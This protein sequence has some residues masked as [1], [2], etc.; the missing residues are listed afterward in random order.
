MRSRPIFLP[1]S[2]SLAFRCRAVVI[3][4]AC[5]LAAGCVIGDRIYTSNIDLLFPG[6]TKEQVRPLI[7]DAGSACGYMKG[8]QWKS[9]GR[10]FYDVCRRE[11]G[12]GCHTKFMKSALWVEAKEQTTAEA[13]SFWFDFVD[14]EGWIILEPRVKI[15]D[16]VGGTK[17][18]FGFSSLGT[19]LNPR[20]KTEYYALKRCLTER[21]G[22]A[23]TTKNEP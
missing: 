7:L 14:S 11:N 1:M 4:I 12:S 23:V 19:P 2:V 21:Y 13:I 8:G 17:V 22:P 20:E 15:E 6:K 18:Q 9:N 16:A 5:L 3:A 10:S